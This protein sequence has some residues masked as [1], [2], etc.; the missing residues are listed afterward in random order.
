MKSSTTRAAW[1][2]IMGTSCPTASGVSSGLI[3]CRY[4]VE[5]G[6]SS[7]IGNCSSPGPLGM[8]MP[9]PCPPWSP[10]ADENVASSRAIRATSA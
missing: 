1:R 8:T 7:S 10:R 5:R 4:S 9:T 2:S 6:G 3:S